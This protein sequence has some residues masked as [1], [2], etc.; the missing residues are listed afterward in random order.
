M[1]PQVICGCMA[2][3]QANCQCVG[4]TWRQPCNAV[5]AS[6]M[7]LTMTRPTAPPT[8]P[9]GESV[10]TE[11]RNASPATTSSVTST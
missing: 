4:S 1:P 3:S 7:S 5:T 2:S 10:V 9:S 11:S 6:R 8:A